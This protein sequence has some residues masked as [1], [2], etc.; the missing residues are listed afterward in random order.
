[1]DQVPAAAEIKPAGESAALRA[2][3]FQPPLYAWLAALGMRFSTDRDPLA[4]VLPSY[5]AGVVVVILVYLHGRLWR[6][7]GMGLAASLLLGFNPNVLL[8]MQEATPTTLA[9]AGAV[10]A[11]LCYGWYQRAASDSVRLWPWAG[12]AFWAVAGGLS[13]GLSLLSLGGFGLIVIPIVILHQSYLRAGP[14][15]LPVT[16]PRPWP[17]R[18]EWRLG[19][20]WIS[21]LV[22]LAIA[23]L[24][25][26][27]WHLRMFQ[28]Y[29]WE[30]AA[31]LELRSWGL[32]GGGNS[33]AARLFEL[34]PVTLPLG[35][36]GFARAVRLALIDE[37]DTPE[38]VG[39]S[40]WVFWLA[41]A[42]LTPVF[43]P[44]APRAVLDLF[45]LVPLSL[46]AALT[47]ADLV[48]RRVP[49]RSL[50]WLAPAT[51][52]SIAWWA[53]EDL[54][55]A[56]IGL[57]RGRI[58]AVTALGLHLALDLILVS[59]WFTRTLDRWARHRDDRQRQVL[60]AFLLSILLITVGTGVQEVV[61][62]HSETHELLT[63]RTMIL[64]RNRE[65]PFDLLAVVASD[66]RTS[67]P[68]S[69]VPSGAP[70]DQQFSGGWLR[71]ILRTALPQLPQRDLSN[72]DDLLVLPEGQRL[73]IF[74]GSGQ[75]LSYPVKS[76]LGLEA[77]HPGRV[78]ILDAYATAHDR[79]S[80]H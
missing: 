15:L 37:N 38:T 61:F 34:A 40:L 1:M 31:G 23:L 42:A 66:P 70:P 62:R 50:V 4:I 44:R 68:S 51:A 35:A 53:S 17:R 36:Y 3:S 12:P 47:T 43:W 5:V 24:I 46:L 80:R 48:N 21:G 57:V 26:L 63:L 19:G 58:D 56:V 74:T 8:R 79:P 2:I 69:A 7:G 59:I 39:A 52:M 76:R 32:G 55:G 65:R 10:G 73:I 9:L 29:G 71:F 41:V 72:V 64:R 33:L 20:V 6:G 45:L 77:I 27:P 22:A 11:L 60:A 49:V 30:V 78:G 67:P 28:A 75:R 14:S 16:R 54:R 13:L 18:L 25:A